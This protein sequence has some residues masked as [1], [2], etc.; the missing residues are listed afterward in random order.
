MIYEILRANKTGLADNMPQLLASKRLNTD[1]NIKVRERT[2]RL[3]VIFYSDGTS[4]LDW[5][6]KGAAGGV[7]NRGIN[8]LKQEE[9]TL[10][11]GG[12]GIRINSPTWQSGRT[13]TFNSGAANGIGI[14]F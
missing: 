7:G 9:K 14:A 1:M 6:I 3:P 5:R 13:L 2:S 12:Y 11:D 4:L 10:P 8:Y